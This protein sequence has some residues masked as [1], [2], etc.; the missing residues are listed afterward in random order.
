MGFSKQT[1]YLTLFV[2]ADLVGSWDF[3]E[4]G[5]AHHFASDGNNK[6]STGADLNFLDSERKTAGGAE[7]LR[8]VR[9]G[10]LGF[11]HADQ[12][13]STQRRFEVSQLVGG[14]GAHKDLRGAIKAGGQGVDFVGEGR[15]RFV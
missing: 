1:G 10:F 11:G 15:I 14:F 9:K 8:V 3:G 12:E 4:T 5:H 13:V 7:E 6:T 2:Q